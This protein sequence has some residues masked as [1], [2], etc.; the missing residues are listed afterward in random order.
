MVQ[1]VISTTLTL[2]NTCHYYD[3][4]TPVTVVSP[5][6]F[7]LVAVYPILAEALAHLSY[8]QLDQSQ[9]PAIYQFGQSQGSA[10]RSERI[11]MTAPLV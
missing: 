11:Q 9:V 7:M 1:P 3:Y 2:R 8:Q 4:C 10:G 6:L 5:V